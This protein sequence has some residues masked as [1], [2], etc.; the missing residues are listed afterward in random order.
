MAAKPKLTYFSSRGLAESIRVLLADAGVEYED[1][2]V[3]SFTPATGFP[4]AF[5]SLVAAGKLPYDQVPIW[6]EPSGF[7]LSQSQAILRHIA[8]TH[9][10]FG[11]NEIEHAFIDQAHEGVIDVQQKIVAQMRIYRTATQDTQKAEAKENA[12]KETAKGLNNFEKLLHKYHDGKGFIASANISYADIS[13][14]YFLEFA[15]DVGLVNLSTYPL[16]K[17]Y[18]ERIE[19]R[20]KIDAYRKSAHRLPL[21]NPFA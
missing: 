11:S 16:L 20:P 3:G 8:R 13:L 15:T 12:Q 7:L 6:E 9:G 1:V 2:G 14:Y 5:K 18:K 19:A 4:E 17:G 10:Y 21:Q